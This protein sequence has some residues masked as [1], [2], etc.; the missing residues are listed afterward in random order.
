MSF[1]IKKSSKGIPDI[2][3]DL[4]EKILKNV[5]YE[6]NKEPNKT[7]ISVLMREHKKIMSFHYIIISL[8][9]I[10]LVLVLLCSLAFIHPQFSLNTQSINQNKI[11]MS[12]EVLKISNPSSVD[13]TIN[14]V[15][16][17]VKK[18]SD[19]LYLVGINDNGELKV[20]VTGFNHQK[21]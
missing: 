19:S 10:A 20:I 13:E 2:P 18:V 11:T 17:P 5:F 12:I 14:N 15:P 6:C 8:G 1:N 21:T 9:M 16:I 7:P 3:I 4:A